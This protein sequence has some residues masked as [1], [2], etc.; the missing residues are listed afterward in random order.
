MYAAR[1]AW[2]A[3]SG[4]HGEEAERQ[5][6]HLK[7]VYSSVP[8]EQVKNGYRNIIS[9]PLVPEDEEEHVQ[10]RLELAQLLRDALTSP[11][12]QQL[13]RVANGCF[14]PQDHFPSQSRHLSQ[15]SRV[16][17]VGPL[18]KDSVILLSEPD[19]SITEK[20]DLKMPMMTL[21]TGYGDCYKG[22]IVHYPAEDPYTGV[23]TEKP[24]SQYYPEAGFYRD[25]VKAGI[26]GIDTAFIYGTEE[27]IG[28]EAPD[29][30]ITTK[31]MTAPFRK[32]LGVL[33]GTDKMVDQLRALKRTSVNVLY[34]HEDGEDDNEW[35]LL[36]E[37]IPKGHAR[38]LGAS[39]VSAALEHEQ[40]VKDGKCNIHVSA[41]QEEIS[42]CGTR[43]N[44]VLQLIMDKEELFGNATLVGHSAIYFC[45]NE[46]ITESIAKRL[47]R[48]VA[49]VAIRANL[50]QGIP[51]LAQTR[52]P[53]HMRQ[54][55]AVFDFSLSPGDLSQI[56]ANLR[57]YR[58]S[59]DLFDE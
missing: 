46:P 13:L 52:K 22:K 28:R 44:K 1:H 7:H 32:M 29:V 55:L 39:D 15:K 9:Y 4:L 25:A 37:E 54:E 8:E 16:R 47:G 23:L 40:C 12:L 31:S 2:V 53:E 18:T 27:Q 36:E 19:G 26:K 56:L 57:L 14:L 41:V 50:E 45:Q 20:D 35:R 6:Q 58:K 42:P 3:L 43:F 21:G 59:S 48:T 24:C 11:S 5:R 17:P 10:K 49:E 38:A 34:N 30:F 33:H 51:M